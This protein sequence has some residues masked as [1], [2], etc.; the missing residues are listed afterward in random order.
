MKFQTDYKLP[1]EKITLFCI[2][3]L[4]INDYERIFKTKFSHFSEIISS[5]LYSEDYFTFK[6]LQNF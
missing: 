2:V 3:S 6:R 5:L 4:N 1:S